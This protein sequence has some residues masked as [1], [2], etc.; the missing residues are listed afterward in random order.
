MV[1]RKIAA[2]LVTALSVLTLSV[3]GL[4][5]VWHYPA[6]SRIMPIA[7]TIA[8][9]ILSAI[10]AIQLLASGEL[11]VESRPQIDKAVAKRLIVIFGALLV[12][13]AG[14]STI[15]F[16]STYVVLIPLTAWL[17]GY[18][19]PKGLAIGTVTFCVALYV[20]FQIVLNRP[21]PLEIW[22]LGA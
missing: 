5:I 19:R 22:M 8:A 3:V 16:F 14:V 20:V 15:G 11:R 7:I 21:L 13:L 6:G 9:A 2:E 12:M 1:S 10:W 17:L 18:R 4:S